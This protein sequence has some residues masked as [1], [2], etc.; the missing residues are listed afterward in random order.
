VQL[1]LGALAFSVLVYKKRYCDTTRRSWNVWARDTAK[2]AL[3]SL[4]GHCWN[5]LFAVLLYD[6]INEVGRAHCL[7]LFNAFAVLFA[8]CCLLSLFAFYCSSQ[9]CSTT[10]PNEVFSCDAHFTA[11]CAW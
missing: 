7:L 5:L 6:S 2:Q 9:F 11:A 4:T 3:G 10:A 1:L 8:S